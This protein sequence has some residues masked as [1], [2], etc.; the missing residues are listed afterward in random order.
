MNRKV[1]ISNRGSIDHALITFI[2]ILRDCSDGMSIK[3]A[4]WIYDFLKENPNKDLVIDIPEEKCENFRTSM[5]KNLGDNIYT[6]LDISV[7]RDRTIL[8]LG[9]GSEKDYIDHIVNFSGI[10][11]DK[12]VFLSYLLSDLNKEDLI[13]MVK[14]IEK[15]EKCKEI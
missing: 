13:N 10:I 4:K 12:G 8:S 9:I 2:K 14:K 7:K 11:V 6:S 5:Y 15:Y 1:I 3:E